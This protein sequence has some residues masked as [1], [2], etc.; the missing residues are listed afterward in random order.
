M[1]WAPEASWWRLVRHCVC[2]ARFEVGSRH[3]KENRGGI[4]T[5]VTARRPS[6]LLAFPR[7]AGAFCLPIRALIEAGKRSATGAVSAAAIS[8]EA[9]LPTGSLLYVPR[10]VVEEATGEEAAGCLYRTTEP[11]DGEGRPACAWMRRRAGDTLHGDAVFSFE[12]GAATASAGSYASGGEAFRPEVCSLWLANHLT[13]EGSSTSGVGVSRHVRFRF[14][15]AE[16]EVEQARGPL[17]LRAMGRDVEVFDAAAVAELAA[18]GARDPDDRETPMSGLRALSLTSAGVAQASAPSTPVADPEGGGARGG[19]EAETGDVSGV[20]RLGYARESPVRLSQSGEAMTRCQYDGMRCA[21]CGERFGTRT[22]ICPGGDGMVHDS[23]RCDELARDALAARSEKAVAAAAAEAAREA[24]AIALAAGPTAVEERQRPYLIALRVGSAENPAGASAV[25]RTGSDQRRAQQAAALSDARRGA[26]RACLAGEC[27]E[28]HEQPMVCLGSFGGG[29][30]TARVHGVRCAQISKGHASLG[31]F[32]CPVCFLRKL[33]SA[34]EDMSGAPESA[35]SVAETSSLVEMSRGAEG[36]GASYADYIRSETAFSL[37]VA[38]LAGSSVSPRDDADVFIMFL[39]WFVTER[40]RALSLDSMF[41][42]A[43]VVMVR[44]RGVDL[45]RDGRVKA[46]YHEL[47]QTHGEESS[48]RT[49]ATRRMVRSLLEIQVPLCVSASLQSRA[50]LMVA[51]ECMC[52]LRVGEVLTGGDF[53]GLLANHMVILTSQS[54]GRVSVEGMIEHSKTKHKRYV[55]AVA[56][57][58]GETRIQLARYLRAYWADTGLDVVARMEAG[59]LVEG[60]DFYVVRVSLM[61]LVG[62]AGRQRL[63]LMGRLLRTSASPMARRWADFS[64]LRGEQRRAAA[65]SMDKRYINVIGGCRASPEIALVSLELTRTGFGELISIVPGPMMR[66]TQGTALGASFMP[67]DPQSTYGKLHEM[68]DAAYAG[69]SPAGD[70]D[71]ELDLAGLASPLWGH[72]SF[73]RFADTVARQTMGETG[74]TEQDID[75]M[76]GWMEAYYSAR[77]QIHYESY[78]VRERRCAVTRLV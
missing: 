56:S 13:A 29:S 47:R 24:A 44:T 73:R 26:F 68:L 32:R 8:R 54:T 17:S 42:V 4:W 15:A 39:A 53:H 37:G 14:R 78:F 25:A 58:E 74:A 50:C 20:R 40:E 63:L 18:E 9:P 5:P 30:C 77:M 16:A 75:L 67:L 19:V 57:S 65:T 1:P 38:Q 23:R 34:L 22:W 72:H 2:V 36:T 12:K 76:F 49:A 69:C 70:P 55:N 61:G 10:R 31:C 3:L 51:L 64:V 6:L 7:A 41:R 33:Y 35:R 45:T 27:S 46:F 21:G 59:Y 43:G 60:P 48:P 66:A 28:S 11:F 62:E 52:G 71:P